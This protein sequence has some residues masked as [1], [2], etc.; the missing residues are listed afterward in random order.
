LLNVRVTG[1]FWLGLGG[2]LLIAA[3]AVLQLLQRPDK[4]T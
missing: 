2:S 4:N 1:W 3:I